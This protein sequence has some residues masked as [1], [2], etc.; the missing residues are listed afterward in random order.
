MPKYEVQ[1]VWLT[2][3]KVSQA[4]GL[5]LLTSIIPSFWPAMSGSDKRKELLLSSRFLTCLIDITIR[6]ANLSDAP[7]I[8]DFNLLLA[9]ETEEL[10]L[11][12]DCVKAGVAALL[13]D[14][15]KGIYYVAEVNGMVVGQLMITYE[16]SDWRNGNLWWIQS[17]YVQRKFRR[18]GVFHALFDYLGALARS[19][20]DVRS[21]RLYMHADNS[22]AR[23]SYVNLGMHRTKYE[24]FELEFEP[25]GS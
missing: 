2:S 25:G 6:Q 13:A 7:V 8:A 24:V 23:Q 20:G 16:W 9:K 15:A 17:V 14:S 4:F 5:E 21:L 3:Q 18:M 22:K 11:D 12:P 10:R 1:A 19:R